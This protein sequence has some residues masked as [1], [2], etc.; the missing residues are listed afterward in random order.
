MR[1]GIYPTYEAAYVN[2]AY[3]VGVSVVLLVFGLLLLKRFHR[4]L[5]ERWG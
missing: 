4:D 2:Q 5:L 1:R 3:V